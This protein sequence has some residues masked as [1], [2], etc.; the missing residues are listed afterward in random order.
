MTL[1]EGCSLLRRGDVRI[2]VV[3]IRSIY[4]VAAK[5]RVRAAG[6]ADPGSREPSDYEETSNHSSC[7]SERPTSSAL[8]LSLSRELPLR[9]DRFSLGD[10]TNLLY[11][12]HS[13]ALFLHLRASSF[14]DVPLCSRRCWRRARS[15]DT[16]G[17]QRQQSRHRR[18][19]RLMRLYR[20]GNP[21]VSG[22]RAATRVFY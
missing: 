12:F 10:A 21:P 17:D 13:F 2:D 4:T 9:E 14:L 8:S 15:L 5:G 3:D 20:A 1:P 19:S 16:P 7:A 18:K 6:K 11:F 22:A